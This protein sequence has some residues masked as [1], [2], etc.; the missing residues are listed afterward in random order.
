MDSENAVKSAMSSQTHIVDK[1][2]VSEE[3]T[4]LLGT[5]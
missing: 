4:S 1:H 5:L 3:N 2:L